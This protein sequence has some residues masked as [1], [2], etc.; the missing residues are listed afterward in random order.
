MVLYLLML[1]RLQNRGTE[2]LGLG[3]QT[4]GLD[5]RRERKREEEE[6]EKEKEKEKKEKE[7]PVLCPRLL[8]TAFGLPGL[9]MQQRSKRLPLG[10]CAPQRRTVVPRAI[11]A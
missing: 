11:T 9:P 10:V 2:V 1:R 8:L 7:N 5:L 6:K 4:P 3:A